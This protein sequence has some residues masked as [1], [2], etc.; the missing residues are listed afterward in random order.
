MTE[1]HE[2]RGT[3]PDPVAVFHERGALAEMVALLDEA[4]RGW[5]HLGKDEKARACAAAIAGLEAGSCSVRV[6][7]TTYSVV[8]E[9]E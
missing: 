3:R 4:G 5:V 7:V 1:T 2:G 8:A 9:N 6:G